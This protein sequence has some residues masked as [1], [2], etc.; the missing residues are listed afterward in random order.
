MKLLFSALSLLLIF[1]LL[2]AENVLYLSYEEP[3]KRV[4]Q[5]EYFPITLKLLSTV[6]QYDDIDYAFYAPTGVKLLSGEPSRIK[7]GNYYYDTFYFR[8]SK[9]LAATPYITASLQSNTNTLN[10]LPLD[11][12]VLNPKNDYANILADSFTITNYKT[13]SYDQENNIVVFSAKALRSDLSKFKF[14]K[15]KKQ[16][17]ESKKF[18]I[19][20]SSITYYAVIDKKEDNL[21][22]TYF[23]LRK[24]KFENVIIPI[25]VDDDRVST[26]S[27]LKPTESKHQK[28]KMI[29]AGVI[30]A[31]L[32]ITLLFKRKIIYLLLAIAPGYYLYI[33]ALPTEFVCIKAN[34]PIQLLPMR[35]GTVFEATET[36]LTLEAETKVGKF[37]KVQLHNTKIGWV[38][39]EYICTP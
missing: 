27:N 19:I 13:T 22:F 9:R 24:Q 20:A 39:D 32:L 2:K 12:V 16:G 14:S 11:V 33:T 28:I 31:L 36:E 25:V 37:T 35:H 18:G 23:N 8:A 15:I 6:G 5:G 10:S 34:S 26:Q 17:F 4:I 30:L 3:P 1:T 7:K 21:V 38:K 29:T